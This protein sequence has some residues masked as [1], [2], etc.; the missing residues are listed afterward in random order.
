MACNNP[1][2]SPRECLLKCA[3]VERTASCVLTQFQVAVNI[4]TMIGVCVNTALFVMTE[5][6]IGYYNVKALTL[7]MEYGLDH[8]VYFVTWTCT[9]FRA[10]VRQISAPETIFLRGLG[11]NGNNGQ[12][13]NFIATDDKE[14]QARNSLF[15]H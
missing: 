6:H 11:G 3:I 2:N 1:H 14:E 10:V 15:R 5:N 12:K 8:I 7:P 9:V 13:K 4:K